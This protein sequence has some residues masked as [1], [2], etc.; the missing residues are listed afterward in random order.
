M[1]SAR[2][3]EHYFRRVSPFGYPRIVVCLRLPEAF[4]RS[5]RPSSALYAKTSA[6]R[7]CLFNLFR[8]LLPSFFR[9]SIDWLPN[10]VFFNYTERL[11]CCLSICLFV[12]FFCYSVFKEQL[13]YPFRS[14]KTDQEFPL[15]GKNVS[16]TSFFSP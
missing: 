3:P 4:R 10:L 12:C 16:C 13:R 1:Y 8:E 6:V 5:L 2:M 15:R 14:L 11:S 7:S 9:H